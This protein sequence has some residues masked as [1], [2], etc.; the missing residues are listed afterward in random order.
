MA[1][2][3]CSEF[4]TGRPHPEHEQQLAIYVEAARALFPGA[5]VAGRRDLRARGNFP[6]EPAS[7]LV[8]LPACSGRI[9]DRCRT[10]LRESAAPVKRP[11]RV[12]CASRAA[13][14]V[15]RGRVSHAA[16]DVEV[17]ALEARGPHC[18]H[19]TTRDGQLFWASA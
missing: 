3:K 10:I 2:S 18:V 19:R 11:I 14:R 16:W 9:A 7:N 5:R 4:K 1:A 8:S 17:V 15:R 13:V 12:R 6:L